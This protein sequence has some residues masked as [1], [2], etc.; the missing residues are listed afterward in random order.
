[1][2]DDRKKPSQKVQSDSLRCSWKYI[3]FWLISETIWL[4]L[5]HL[6]LDCINKLF[7]YWHFWGWSPATGHW[8]SIT[9]P[10]MVDAMCLA[11]RG[12]TCNG[13]AS[14]RVS[15]LWLCTSLTLQMQFQVWQWT[16]LGAGTVELSDLLVPKERTFHLCIW[17][18][19][20][21]FGGISLH[22]ISCKLN[23]FP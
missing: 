18:T 17:N 15:T 9:W 22:C 10:T 1:M 13:R 23:E 20:G 12:P 6:F 8:H 14:L 5:K 3:N 7:C 21:L 2:H 4:K 19:L 11:E 16:F